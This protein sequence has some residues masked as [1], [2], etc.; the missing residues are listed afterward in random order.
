MLEVNGS[1]GW[2]A[3]GLL[4]CRKVTLTLDQSHTAGF[5]LS[6]QAKWHSHRSCPINN[7]ADQPIQGIQGSHLLALL[8][9]SLSFFPPRTAKNV[10]DIEKPDYF[11][12]PQSFS[13][14]EL[15]S[16]FLPLFLSVVFFKFV[17]SLSYC[18]HYLYDKLELGGLYTQ[19]KRC[20]IHCIHRCVVYFFSVMLKI[21]MKRI[22]NVE[23]RQRESVQGVYGLSLS[24]TDTGEVPSVHNMSGNDVPLTDVSRPQEADVAEA[25]SPHPAGSLFP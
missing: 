14:S 23:N 19:C 6:S 20:F 10:K 17:S 7:Q 16:L 8:I 13:M 5:I 9:H 12:P 2:W 18:T 11:P 3:S 25:R 15:F 4:H 21:L 22:W 1:G 24:Y